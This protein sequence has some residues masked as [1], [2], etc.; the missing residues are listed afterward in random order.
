MARPKIVSPGAVDFILYPGRTQTWTVQLAQ[1]PS[2]ARLTTKIQL[3]DTNAVQVKVERVLVCEAREVLIPDNSLPGELPPGVPHEP[4]PVQELVVVRE[5]DG[6]TPVDVGADHIV[7]I[8]IAAHD[9]RPGQDSASGTLLIT[10]DTWD[11]ISVPL[12]V[13]R[14]TEVISDFHP[15]E[16]SARQGG[17]AMTT[18]TV[19]LA[20]GPAVDLEYSMVQDGEAY[21][22]TME[23]P[24]ARLSISPGDTK[25]VAFTFRL[26]RQ[27]PV[28]RKYLRIV[29]TGALVDH[30]T[31]VLHVTPFSPAAEAIQAKAAVLAEGPPGPRTPMSDVEDAGSGGF[32]QRFSSGNIYWHPATG[33]KWVYGAILTKYRELGGPSGFLGYPRTDELNTSSARGRLNEFQGGDIYFSGQTGAQEMHGRILDRWKSLGAEN[34]YLGFPTFDQRSH[35]SGQMSRLQ[36]GAIQFLS[37][38][39]IFDVSDAR[40]VKTGV[41]NVDGAAANGWAELSLSSSGGWKFKGSMRST[42][43]LGYDVLMVMSIDLRAFGGPVI[44]FAEKG[45]VEGTLV[46]GGSRT[47]PWDDFDMDPRIKDHWD[48]IRTARVTTTFTVDF[49]PGD[50]LKVIGSI[51]AVPFVV[52]A[53]IAV[54][55]ILG[56]GMVRCGRYRGHEHFNNETKQWERMEGDVWVHKG[57]I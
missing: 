9:L 32:V 19:R 43:A 36:R 4:T 33:A 39:F 57:E 24:I 25:T 55:Q 29:Q 44:A 13:G 35:P 1:L 21:G 37:N 46:L 28:G 7:K 41:I 8:D 38:E 3:D 48:L 23:P 6:I 31:L 26:G 47:H 20:S 50:L 52:I 40:E 30:D 53:M 22:V 16:L 10:G 45:D 51:L 42:G 56:A 5:S 34:S 27:A 14:G 18:I 11:S 15:S 49:G 12:R 17:A 2:A 54:G